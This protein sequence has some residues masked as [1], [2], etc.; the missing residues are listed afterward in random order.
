MV[1]V[2]L[3]FRK[4]LGVFVIANMISAVAFEYYLS[5]KSASDLRKEFLRMQFQE[6]SLRNSISY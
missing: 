4:V 1:D 5:R 6:Q 2:P 3:P